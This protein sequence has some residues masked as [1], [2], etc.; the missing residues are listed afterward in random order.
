MEAS[1]F[2]DPGRSF[3]EECND[4]DAWVDVR[5]YPDLSLWTPCPSFPKNSYPYVVFLY[6]VFISD[7][8]LTLVD[9]RV[10]AGQEIPSG[11]SLVWK[12][13]SILSFMHNV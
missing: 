10:S 9:Q 8:Y 4:L 7:A 5:Y 6:F 11:V 2:L 13:I 12:R 1:T 3:V